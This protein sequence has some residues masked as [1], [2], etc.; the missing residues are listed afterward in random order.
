MPK[1]T[2]LKRVG[3]DVFLVISDAA[4]TVHATKDAAYITL[5]IL[6]GENIPA[7]VQLSTL[8]S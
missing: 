3:D 7:R 1:S 5:R 4:V 8:L 2:T 6:R